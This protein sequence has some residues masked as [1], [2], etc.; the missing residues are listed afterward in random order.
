MS[1]SNEKFDFHRFDGK[2]F[3]LWKFQMRIFLL[4]QDL[5]NIVEGTT[6]KPA[7]GAEAIAEWTKKDHRAM[8]FLT[9]ALSRTQLSFVVN[10]D[11]SK[12]IWERLTSIHEQRNKTSIHMVHAEFY[13]YQMNP[14]DD[15]ATH[16]TKVESLARR[17]KDLGEEPKEMAV[18]TKIL[19]SLPP[20]YRTLL[21]AWDSTPAA[22]QTLANLTARLLKEQEVDKKMES[23]TLSSN[24]ALVASGRRNSSG[25]NRRQQQQ[26]GNKKK[27]PGECFHCKK[28]GHRESDCWQK[29]PEKKR[30]R[31]SGSSGSANASELNALMADTEGNF[32]NAWI[33]DSGASEHMCAQKDWFIEFTPLTPGTFPVTIANKSVMQ[34][35]G[36]GIVAVRSKVEGKWITI[37]LGNV[38][39]VPDLGRNLFSISSASRN[40]AMVL[41]TDRDCKV[42]KGKQLLATGENVG[43]LYRMNFQPIPRNEANL[44]EHKQEANLQLWHQRLGHANHQ[45]IR[46]AIRSDDDSEPE[47]CAG[48]L[49]GKQH[50]SSFPQGPKQRESVPG[51][52]IH[53]DLCGPCTP[54]SLGRSKFFLLIKD[55][56]TNMSFIYFLKAKDET[57]TAFKRFL[58]DWAKMSDNPIRGLRSDNGTEFVNAAFNAFLLE[59]EIRHE[60]SITY[61]PEMNGFIERSIRT[62]TECARSMI[63]GS[64]MEADLWAEAC[65][66]AVYVL[67]RL[68]SKALQYKSPFEAL[69]GDPPQLH[70]IRIFGSDAFVHVRSQQQ[71]GKFGKKSNPE[72]VLVGYHPDLLAYKVMNVK[73]GEIRKE[74]NVTIDESRIINSRNRQDSP[75]GQEGASPL[76]GHHIYENTEA[77]FN[78]KEGDESLVSFE[79]MP[80]AKQTQADVRSDEPQNGS[81]EGNENQDPVPV[82]QSASSSSTAHYDVPAA[83]RRTGNTSAGSTP[84]Q[85]DMLIHRTRAQK[86]LSHVNWIG[87]TGGLEEEDDSGSDT[88]SGDEAESAHF[89]F[90]DPITVKDALTS[91]DYKQWEKA[92]QSEMDALKEQ[93]AW[94]LC[95]R[96]KNKNVI[97]NRWIFKTKYRPDGSIE[98]H[99]ARLVAKGFTQQYGRDYGET[100][101]PVVRFDTVRL[102]LSI[103]QAKN[104]K[105]K[106]ID[107]VG[108]YLYGS[109][110]EEIY[111]EEPECFK[112]TRTGNT[113]CK[114]KKSLYGL[115]QSARQW[116][117]K[118]TDA[119]R[120]LGLEAA[121]S[122]PCLFTNKTFDLF[123]A[124][125]VDDGLV[126][127]N[128]EK[129][130]AKIISLLEDKFKVTVGDMHSFVG[131]QIERLPNGHM[132]LHQESY[133]KRILSRFRMEDSKTVSTP[134]D[135]GIKLTKGKKGEGPNSFPYREAVG[136]LNFL[137]V[138][139]RPDI[140]FAVA[141]LS[142]YSDCAGAEHWTAVKRLLRYLKGS[143]NL[144]ITFG[145]GDLTLV[146]FSDADHANDEE[147]RRSRTGIVF[148]MN[149]G[150]VSWQSQKQSMIATSTCQAEYGAAFTAA[151]HIV[152]SREMLAQMGCKQTDP[153]PLHVDNTGAIGAVENPDRNFKRTKHWD[154]Q[155]KYTNEQ[156]SLN[157]IV[158]TRV[159]S[160]DQFADILTK[161]L[162]PGRFKQNVEQLNI[163]E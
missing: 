32:R 72:F 92:M 41:L 137:A 50:R 118:F 160:T 80:L 95:L 59:K 79:M 162:T 77:T 48:C 122:D 155:H 105:A 9:Q 8:M 134:V 57:L 145:G 113:V 82:L 24:E 124:L 94:T 84:S 101:S 133:T 73:T 120:S 132:K 15:V 135:S 12:G 141:M 85:P 20:S 163:S 60:T 28:T 66:T 98:K 146:A 33:A 29:Y 18:I 65:A 103:I 53:M 70:H 34:S 108:A 25:N 16:I 100:F 153:T 39:Y 11:T 22:E 91:P 104:L 156:V 87:A 126:A 78:Q 76:S 7:E 147:T 115:K 96:P 89:A 52:L 97:Q 130:V 64:G 36:I 5:W 3:Y 23:L 151:K 86:N 140:A 26:A 46:K 27:F 55:D 150:C 144:G 149:S 68:P 117:R 51:K 138:C 123:F 43:K 110:E 116:N 152:W 61:C 129:A 71:E 37:T 13:D 30:Q 45:L 2:D 81:S 21:S 49:Y 4:G 148:M 38:L 44:C 47:V 161:P 143:A 88:E 54:L 158:I 14:K 93:R 111:M 56:A 125:Y 121:A 109:L 62:V 1:M 83:A 42:I 136:A 157:Q 31:S 69:T 75:I 6:E 17:L 106:Q 40:K 58:L 74:I 112:T 119:L 99:K 131:I 63:H 114:L 90:C 159:S 35:L 154:I 67:N 142:Q 128:D 107:I 102:L 19:C 139:T 127:G 10:C